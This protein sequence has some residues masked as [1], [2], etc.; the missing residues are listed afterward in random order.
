MAWWYIIF[1]KVRELKLSFEEVRREKKRKLEGRKD[2][3]PKEKVS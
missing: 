2:K 1:T 3:D